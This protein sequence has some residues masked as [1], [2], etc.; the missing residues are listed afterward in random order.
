MSAPDRSPQQPAQCLWQGRARLGEGPMWSTELRCLLFVDILGSRLMSHDPD[1]GETRAWDLDEACCWLVPHADGGFVAGLRSRLV[2]LTLEP[3]GPRILETLATPVAATPGHRLNDGKAD[4][5]GRL[6]F[7]IMDVREQ[8]ASGCLLRY[9]ARGL[10]SV[11]TPYTVTNGPAISADGTTL[12][13][14]DSPARTLYAFDIDAEGDLVDKRV[15]L[16][17]GEADGFPDGMTLDAEGGLWVAHW[18]GG[19]VTRFLPDGRRDREI[20]LPVSRVT[21]CTFGGDDL[22]TLYITTA[23]VGCDDQQ[24]AG[25]LF[26]VRPGVQGLAPCAYRP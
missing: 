14:T 24:L 21:C 18:D 9:D 4:P 2:H 20:V 8:E 5:R 11:D 26:A 16:R 17:F 7:G 25:A 15:H 12:Y 19:R 6:W 1:T 13:H 3:Q 22:A 10:A 23:A